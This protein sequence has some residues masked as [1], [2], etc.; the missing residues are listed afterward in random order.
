MRG[1][2]VCEVRKKGGLYIPDG[3]RKEAHLHLA[4][5]FKARVGGGSKDIALLRGVWPLSGVHHLLPMLAVS[6]LSELLNLPPALL[7]LAL[8]YPSPCQCDRPNNDADA[9]RRA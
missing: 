3:T 7:S 1:E 4:K 8:D 9:K 5:N 2:L 6:F